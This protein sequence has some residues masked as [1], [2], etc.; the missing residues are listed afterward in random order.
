ML[1]NILEVKDDFDLFIFDI[2]GVLWNGNSV[3][4]NVP[5]HLE[6]LKKANKTV[7]FLSNGHERFFEMEETWAKRGVIKNVHYDKI[8][9]SGELAYQCFCEDTQELNYYVYGKPYPKMFEGCK[10]KQV[11]DVKKADFVYLGVPK[12]FRNNDWHNVFDIEGFKQDLDLFK[13]L[14]KPIVCCNPDIKAVGKSKGEFAIR[15]GA[16]A[17]YYQEIGGEVE[18][19]GKPYPEVFALALEDYDNIEFEKMLMIGDTLDTDILGAKSLG[20]KTAFVPTGMSYA[21]M[22]E[23]TDFEDIKE[24]A[25]YL[26]I[27]PDYLIKSV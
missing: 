14:K 10:Y 9:S 19:L 21:Y 22:K 23:D 5:E 6:T 12:V 7:I 26:G 4:K 27:V 2:Y 25:Q 3:I 11:K 13:K 20:I 8:V 16:L 15:Q 17:Q 18:Y 1:E 24:Y